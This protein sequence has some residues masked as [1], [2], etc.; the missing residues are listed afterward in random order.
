MLKKFSFLTL[1]LAMLALFSVACGAS[2]TTPEVVPSTVPDAT[3]APTSTPIV[4]TATPDP[5]AT[6]PATSTPIV[7][8][9]TPE[10]TK[11]PGVKSKGETLIIGMPS[12]ITTLNPWAAYGADNTVYNAYVLNPNYPALFTFAAPVNSW[13]PSTATD[14]P[15]ELVEEGEFWVSEVKLRQDFAWSDGTPVT[16]GDFVFTIDTALKLELQN[17]WASWYKSDYLDRVEAVDDHTL[18]LYYSQKPGLAVH[19]Y[20]VLVGAAMPKHFWEA[21]VAPFLEQAAEIPA[22][23]ELAEEPTEEDQAAYDTA[24]EERTTALSEIANELFLASAEGEPG[25]GAFKDVRWEEGVAASNVLNEKYSDAGRTHIECP[26]GGYSSNWKGGSFEAYGGC[27]D[28]AEGALKLE[29]GPFFN[30]EIFQVFNTDTLV[31]ALQKGDIDVAWTPNGLATG[32]VEQLKSNPNIQIATNPSNGFRYMA[33]NFAKPYWTKP[34]RQ[35]I[36]CMLDK[37]FLASRVLGGAGLPVN[38]VVPESITPWY[39]DSIQ[40]GCAGLTAQ[41]R[42][43]ETVKILTDAGYTWETAPTADAR[44]TVFE[45]TVLKDP[46]GNDFPQISLL[47]PAYTYDPLRAT[48]A[49]TIGD[50]MNKLGMPTKVDLTAF[51]NIVGV[52]FEPEQ[53]EN[54]DF[55]ILGW[56]LTL[57]PDHMCEF[58]QTTGGSNNMKYSNADIDAACE[59]FLSATTIDDAL[60]HAMKLQ[61]L[62]NDDLPYITLFT[63]PIRDGFDVSSVNYQFTVNLDGL[64][65]GQHSMMYAVSE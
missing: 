13:I 36:S 40:I 15:T 4:V 9:A 44:G 45:G 54:W 53:Q 21:T 12:D 26:N 47:A 16:A 14:F 20:G 5:S 19:Q 30:S 63:T 37:E 38:S 39:N 46:D 29:E 59:Q 6:V 57:F 33:F 50:Y 3:V 61:E 55:Y 25:V 11:E 64:D 22:L 43:S 65:S 8:T 35:A 41:E 52:V 24:A 31:L 58:F 17:A 42:F 10:P 7:V 32:Q 51:N 2:E 27:A 49:L 1:L 23:P 60:P 56:G 48:T 18:K 28:D 34:V 62:I